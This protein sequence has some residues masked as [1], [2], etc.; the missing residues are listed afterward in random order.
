MLALALGVAAAVALASCGGGSDAKLLPG[1]TAQEI[2]KN[3]ALVRELAAEGE[4]V[5]AEDAAL[6]VSTQV[7]DLQ[8]ID[9]KLKQALQDGATKLNE[10][11]LTCA[12]ETTEETTEESQPT[13]TETTTTKPKP[14]KAKK[15]AKEKPEPPG[16]AEPEPAEPPEETTPSGPPNG[17]AKGHE[18]PGEGNG[19]PSGGIGP[20]GAAGGGE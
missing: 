7:E 3:L 6:Q 8:G 16:H 20:G 13:T 12:E 15:P 14:E 11:V 19:P 17:E 9:P 4:C 1:A 18:E 2:I 10:V 5:D